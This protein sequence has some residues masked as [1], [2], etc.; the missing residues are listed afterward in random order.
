M[1]RSQILR[2]NIIIV[3][4]QLD[5][6]EVMK[7]YLNDYDTDK[8]LDMALKFKNEVSA[9]SSS[10]EVS[11]TLASILDLITHPFIKKV[12]GTNMAMEVISFVVDGIKMMP[13]F[14]RAKDDAWRLK[15]LA[16]LM[17]EFEDVV[18]NNQLSQ[19]ARQIMKEAGKDLRH[20]ASMTGS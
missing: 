18:S 12:F 10:F 6:R 16:F 11:S 4:T 14:K 17:E 5:I 13:F 8:D 2:R 15:R 19:A 3:E 7:K 1:N 20:L 9:L